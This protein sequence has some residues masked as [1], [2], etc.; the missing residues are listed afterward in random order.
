MDTDS[1]TLHLAKNNSELELF[2]QWRDRYMREDI[3]PG[4]TFEPATDEDYEWFFSKEYRDVIMEA[5]YRD[6]NTLRIVYLRNAGTN[7]GFAVYVIY[8]T[9]DNKCLIV[10]FNVDK[11]YRNKGVGTLF[12]KLL[13]DQVRSEKA[14]YFALNLTNED[15]E[16]FWMRNGFSKAAKDEQGS[17]VYEKRPL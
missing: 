15:N 10:E 12:F 14:E 9:E 11:A 16:R 17:F 6:V 4:S 13:R 5:F 1:F 8:H 2:W 7:I 3:L